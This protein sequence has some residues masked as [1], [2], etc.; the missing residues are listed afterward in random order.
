[1]EVCMD[2]ENGGLFTQSS[3]RKPASSKLALSRVQTMH[4]VKSFGTPCDKAPRK[5]LGN[6]NQQTDARKSSTKKATSNKVNGQENNLDKSSEK[7]YPEIDTFIPYSPRDYEDFAV[8][9]DHK[10]SHLCLAG[11]PLWISEKD[12]ET[13][14]ALTDAIISPMAMVPVE[15]DQNDISLPFE[16]ISIDLPSFSL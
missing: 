10:L 1:M 9:E 15:F 8:P 3:S 7:I 4:N 2:K 14:D 5:A 13:F 12:K 6:V 11:V 16:D